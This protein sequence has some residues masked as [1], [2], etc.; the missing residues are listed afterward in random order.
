MRYYV[1]FKI[2]IVNPPMHI[3]RLNKYHTLTF[4]QEN[5]GYVL[6]GFNYIFYSNSRPWY[7]INVK[8]NES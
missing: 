5:G 4:M 7:M 1:H 3:A 2:K 8:E 6:S